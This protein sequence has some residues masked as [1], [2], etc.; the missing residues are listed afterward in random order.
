MNRREL[1]CIECPRGCNI[2]VETENEKIIAIV[3]NLCEKG[4]SYAHSEITSPVR[5]LCSTV[6]TSWGTPLSVKTS[7]PISKADMF[8]IMK[9]INAVCISTNVRIGDIIIKNADGNGADIVATDCREAK[10]G[11]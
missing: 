10:S 7:K 11:E 3:G 2:A 4:A 6:R 9:K 8:E 1:T 5:T